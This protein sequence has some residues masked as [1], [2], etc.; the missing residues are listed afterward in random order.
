MYEH[1]IYPSA[2]LGG[3][4]RLG[5]VEGLREDLHHLGSRLCIVQRKDHGAAHVLALRGQAAQQVLEAVPLQF[6]ERPVLVLRQ[7]RVE[8]IRRTFPPERR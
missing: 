3:D 2:Y 6:R 8:L 5:D 7:R 1:N 4:G